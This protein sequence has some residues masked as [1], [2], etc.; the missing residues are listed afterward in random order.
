MCALGFITERRQLVAV[1]SLVRAN[2]KASIECVDEHT[3][4]EVGE[5]YSGEKLAEL[6]LLAGAMSLPGEKWQFRKFENTNEWA[7]KVL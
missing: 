2:G 1:Y 4:L 6:G 3:P 5:W 7:R